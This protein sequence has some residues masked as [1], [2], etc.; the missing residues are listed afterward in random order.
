[1]SIRLTL[2]DNATVRN[3]I[4]EALKP[5][6]DDADYKR[7]FIVC[8][9][10]KWVGQEADD[11]LLRIVTRSDPYLQ[12]RRYPDVSADIFSFEDDRRAVVPFAST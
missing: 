4:L 2:A 10:L 11:A 1:M 6:L 5:L 9:V 8:Q 7:V 12:I 3:G